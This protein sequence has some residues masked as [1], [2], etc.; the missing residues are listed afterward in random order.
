MA[1]PYRKL[2]D[3]ILLC[4]AL[5]T[6]ALEP[7]APVGMERPPYGTRVSFVCTRCTTERHDIIDGIG[8]ISGRRYI[9][10]DGYR[11]AEKADRPALRRELTRRY[12]SKS[13]MF[14]DVVGI[15]A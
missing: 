14:A 1:R 4:H 10:P 15:S 6:H 5:R 7:F 8:R 13:V 12:S 9:Y 2:N 3:R 11:L